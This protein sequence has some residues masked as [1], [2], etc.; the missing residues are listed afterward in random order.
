MAI[1]YK[2]CCK[3]ESVN[4]IY[5][6]STNQPATR[7]YQHKKACELTPNRKVY[8]FI[9]ENGGWQNWEMVTLDEIDYKGDISILR[10]AE[11]YWY[12]KLLPSLNNNQIIPS[13][14]EVNKRRKDYSDKYYQKNKEHLKQVS[15]AYAKEHR[16]KTREY[17]KL[18][19]I[20]NKDA[21]RERFR[22]KFE[23]PC[24]GR[25]F[26]ANKLRHNNTKKHLDWVDSQ[27]N[28]EGSEGSECSEGS[29]AS[30]LDEEV[31]S[32][33]PS[34]DSSSLKPFGGINVGSSN[35]ESNSS[36]EVSGVV[37][38]SSS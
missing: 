24:G 12:D 30:S 19:R 15:I 16:Q 35:S 31:V 11:R 4:D 25:Y 27:F 34:E 1:V 3:D 10:R 8:K 14:E 7:K 32:H 26:Y 36:L 23:C 22:E 5:I 9:N 13:K 28:L 38:A 18:Y 2:I 6:G 29:E 17:Q 33:S 37:T 20:Q 21:I